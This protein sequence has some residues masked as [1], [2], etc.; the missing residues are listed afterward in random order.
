MPR[1]TKREHD[2]DMTGAGDDS[3]MVAAMFAG[4]LNEAERCCELLREHGIPAMIG[5]EADG[6]QSRA[7][8]IPLLVPEP[9]LDNAAEILASRPEHDDDSDGAIGA[10]DEDEE[11]DEDGDDDYDDDE[12][13]AEDEESWD[14]DDDDDEFDDDEDF[15]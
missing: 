13:G 8:G 15:E 4:T 5:D 11:F 1:E 10:S 2:H 3:T 14:D 12:F 6:P 7:V 9:M